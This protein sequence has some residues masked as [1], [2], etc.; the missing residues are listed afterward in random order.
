MGAQTWE[1]EIKRPECTTFL[2]RNFSNVAVQLLQRS[3]W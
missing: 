1:A 2:Q 3:F